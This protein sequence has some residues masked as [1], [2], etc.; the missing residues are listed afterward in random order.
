MSTLHIVYGYCKDQHKTKLY[1]HL[2]QNTPILRVKTIGH[3]ADQAVFAALTY[4]PMPPN[5]SDI[6]WVQRPIPNKKKTVLTD[7]TKCPTLSRKKYHQFELSDKQIK[8]FQKV[9]RVYRK[10]HNQ[11]LNQ[12]NW[13]QHINKKVV[14]QEV[15]NMFT[16]THKSTFFL[17]RNKQPT[18]YSTCN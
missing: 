18:P 10:Q 8:Q 17:A 14:L 7:I 2:T 6:F 12:K 5:V 13:R 15:S 3:I 1:E 4:S 16:P 9:S 11:T